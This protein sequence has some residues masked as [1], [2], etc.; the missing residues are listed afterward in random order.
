MSSLQLVSSGLNPANDLSDG[1]GDTGGLELVLPNR[2][3]LPG[4]ICVRG[5]NA[6]LNPTSPD[7]CSVV[8]TVVGEGVKLL[9]AEVCW[10][11][12]WLQFLEPFCSW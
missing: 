12:G 10:P 11:A 9:T 2:M 5:D 8:V 4:T 1:V 6:N 3:T 7:C